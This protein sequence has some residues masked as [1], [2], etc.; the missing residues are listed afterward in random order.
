VTALGLGTAQLG[1]PYGV[2]NRGGQPSEAEAAAIVRCALGAGVGT[3]DTAPA[4]GEAEALLGRLLP[5]G[6]GVRVVTKT[7]PFAGAE[8]TAAACDEARRSAERSLE[9]LRRDSLDGL[10][11]HHGS[12]LSLPGGERLARCLTELRDAGIA[13]RV[14]VSVYTV[15]ELDAARGLMPLD[16]VQLPL[17]A[18]DQRFLRGG[19]L[20]DLR[21][22]GVEVH[23][24]SAF[25]QGLL[26][27]GP[28]E[29]PAHLAAAA[30]PLRR[31]HEARRRAGL[32]P[33]E[34]ALGLVRS[35]P[36][37]DVALVGANSVPELEECLAAL[38]GPAGPGVDYPPL[39]V[40]DPLI[41]DPRRWTP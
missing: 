5:A 12:E 9:R 10:L 30:G 28:G 23:A 25:L 14:G 38:R 41:V 31:Y 16:L 17:N 19:A 32:T 22:A 33:I 13:K 39:G 26:L 34:A 11:V 8:L 37:V 18:L 40:D 7:P 27:M 24:R 20:D 6:A 35:L 4:Y 21:A 15:E 2:S 29:L 1:L 36:G 3:I